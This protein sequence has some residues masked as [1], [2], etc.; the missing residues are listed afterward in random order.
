L[1]EPN[2]IGRIV[3]CRHRGYLFQGA[4]LSVYRDCV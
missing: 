2:P 4:E 1:M 3:G